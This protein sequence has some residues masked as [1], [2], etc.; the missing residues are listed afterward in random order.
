MAFT[1]SDVSAG[2]VNKQLGLLEDALN[3]FLKLQSIVRHHPEVLY[4]LGTLYESV[5]DV[6]QGIE[7]YVLFR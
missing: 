6:D 3:C 7:W 5:G 1:F 4:Q 2:L